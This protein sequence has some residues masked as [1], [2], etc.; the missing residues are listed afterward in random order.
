MDTFWSTHG[1]CRQI[2]RRL[3]DIEQSFFYF[4]VVVSEDRIYRRGSTLPTI[5]YTIECESETGPLKETK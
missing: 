4:Q 5:L 2:R 3:L 1:I